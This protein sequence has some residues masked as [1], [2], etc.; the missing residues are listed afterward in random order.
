MS[1]IG[2][3]SDVVRAMKELGVSPTP[4]ETPRFKLMGADGWI[5]A[6]SKPGK[7]GGHR[8]LKIYGRLDCP[9]A[10]R[11]I[12]RG[13]YTQHRVF[14]KDEATAIAAGFRPCAKC[15]PEKYKEWKSGS[16]RSHP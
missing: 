12:A 10:L 15:L 6:S 3:G 11:F 2:K 14:F 5:R 16:E 9:S 4:E 1:P 13:Q 8:K 7:L